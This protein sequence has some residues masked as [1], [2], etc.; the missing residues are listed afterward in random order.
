MPKLD[1]KTAK[2]VGDTEATHGGDFPLL[3]PGDYLARL[4]GVEL[5]E[6]NKY[7]AAQW[8]AE[9]E[10]IHAL[11]GTR[12][13]GRQWLNLT[14]P[15]SNTPHP[16]YENGADKWEK[17]QNMLRGRLSAFFEAF[18]YSADSDTDEMLGEW[19]KIHIKQGTIQSGPK[20]G[21]K[22]NEIDDINPVPDDVELPE[23]EAEET[24][25]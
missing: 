17:Y 9:F 5:R 19:A 18:G 6:P 15:S 7:D 22:R 14:L 10:E 1:S 25:F 11:D 8:S 24:S 20:L 2:T 21:E 16:K 13:P 3:E 4:A 23:V 12:Q